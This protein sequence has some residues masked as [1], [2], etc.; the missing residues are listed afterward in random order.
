MFRLHLTHP[1]HADTLEFA[2]TALARLTGPDLYLDDR[3]G[4]VATFRNN[5]WH[6][7]GRS[8]PALTVHGPATVAFDA[9]AGTAPAEAGSHDRLV[10]VDG[11]LRMN[12]RV[13]LFLARLDERQGHWVRFTDG[14][15][16]P[17]VRLTATAG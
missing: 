9:G 2:P 10:V 8:F 15:P 6:A 11:W 13:P 4:P 3:A 16:F 7:S 12:E 5:C 1:A 17:A 14:Q